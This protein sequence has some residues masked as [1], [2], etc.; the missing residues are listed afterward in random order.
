MEAIIEVETFSMLFCV[1][2]IIIVKTDTAWIRNKI[3]IVIKRENIFDNYRI[4]YF[5][6]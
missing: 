6:N 1:C 2:C 5:S 3:Q 4:E